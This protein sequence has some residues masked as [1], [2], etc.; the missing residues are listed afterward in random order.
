MTTLRRSRRSKFPV[1]LTAFAAAA[2]VLAGCSSGGG[3]GGGS[4]ASGG[5]SASTITLGVLAPLSGANENGGLAELHGAQIAVDQINAAGGIKSLGGAKLKLVSADSSSTSTA[6]AISAAQQLVADNPAAILGAVSSTLEIPASTVSEQKK[7][8]SC[9]GALSDTLTSRGYKYLFQLPPTATQLA[10]NA[11]PNFLTFLK[12]YYPNITKVAVVYD[13]NPAETGTGQAFASEL[14][15]MNTNVKV[16]LNKQYPLNFTDA[17]P[18]AAEIK[19]SG[20]QVIVPGSLASELELI[21][22]A[23]NS[24]GVSDLPIFN[25]GGGDATGELWVNELGKYAN[26]QYVLPN[27]AE[28]ANLGSDKNA[29]LAAANA[30]YVKDYKQPF[31]GQYAGEYYVCTQIIAQ[32]MENAKSASPSA[33]RDAMAGHTFSTGAASLYPPGQVTFGSTGLNTAGTSVIAQFCNG[34]LNVVGPP[35]LATSKAQSTT[36]CGGV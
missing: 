8:P 31:M 2:V 10:K 17:A 32:A 30:A 6:T 26:G 34:K 25:A 9:V 23:L 19:A 35:A 7:I 15:A 3:G 13:S 4:G 11:V 36:A 27:F 28:Q 18:L 14:S 33:I 21:I 5:G 1:A 29:L 12:E 20:A 22:G 16:V 24:A